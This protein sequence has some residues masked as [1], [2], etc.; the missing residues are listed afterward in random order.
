MKAEFM[1]NE[2]CLVLGMKAVF[3]PTKAVFST[4]GCVSLS[5]WPSL[6]LTMRRK[7]YARE[8][9]AEEGHRIV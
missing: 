4:E 3:S 7:F 8:K 1:S 5:L 9:Y 6:I 2:G